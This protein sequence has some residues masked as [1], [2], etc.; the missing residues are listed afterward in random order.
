MPLV[1]PLASSSTSGAGARRSAALETIRAVNGVSFVIERGETFGLVGESGCGKS[2]TGRCI[3]RLS[4]RPPARCVE[5]ATTWLAF[6]RSRLRAARRQM[7]IVFQDPYSSARPA[8]SA[9]AIVEEPL[10]IHRSAAGPSDGACR[11][12]VRLVAS[13]P[14]T[15][16][17]SARVSAAAS[18]QSHRLARALALNPSLVI[19]DEP[20]SSLDVSGRRR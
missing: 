8:Q 6:G 17:A 12:A 11:R 15:S 14:T 19:A 16:I 18:R 3:L 2:T 4:S 7:Q 5:R 13:T 9:A 20:V 10:V 1:S